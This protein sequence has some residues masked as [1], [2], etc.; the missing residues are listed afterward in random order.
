M[1]TLPFRVVSS[2]ALAI[3]LNTG[4]VQAAEPAKTEAASDE[5]LLL[6][7]PLDG[8]LRDTVLGDDALVAGWDADLKSTGLPPEPRFHE[9]APNLGK[10]ILIDASVDLVIPKTVIM[11][12]DSLTLSCWVNVTEPGHL[13]MIF[14]SRSPENGQGAHRMGFNMSALNNGHVVVSGALGR[15]RINWTIPF[16]LADS[17]WHQI[18]LTFTHVAGA[19]EFVVSLSMD[20]DQ[21]EQSEPTPG[22]LS[23]QFSLTFGGFIWGRDG[24]LGRSATFLLDDVR[25]QGSLGGG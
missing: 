1:A 7:L 17:Q 11:D 22:R 10:A 6:H 15:D 12:C 14:D 9:G 23:D 18:A 24:E 5:G 2:I 13:F 21:V 8:D 16:D 4:F 3:F 20:G 19:D 25:V